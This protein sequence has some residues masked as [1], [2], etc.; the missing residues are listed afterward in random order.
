I[1]AI[2]AD[3]GEPCTFSG[4]NGAIDLKVGVGK[5]A[6]GVLNPT[7]PRLVTS[8]VLVAAASVTDNDS[9]DEP[10]GVV[11]GYDIDSGKLLWNWD[12]GNPDA[13]HPR[14]AAAA[15]AG[16]HLRPHLAEQV[17]RRER[18]RSAGSRLPA[19]GQSDARH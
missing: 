12:S 16:P 19:D 6:L 18:R 13:G 15:A 4:T 11:R 2:N 7:S 8:H 17:E 5:V 3:T 1:V 10:S 9:T 14:R